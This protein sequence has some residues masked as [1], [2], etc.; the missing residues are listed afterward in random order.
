MHSCDDD[1]DDARVTICEP[2]NAE[3]KA[4]PVGANRQ[5]SKAASVVTTGVDRD[6]ISLERFSDAM[7]ECG[8]I[9]YE[10]KRNLYDTDGDYLRFF[11]CSVSHKRIWESDLVSSK[12]ERCNVLA[13]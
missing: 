4:K 9:D 12:L 1:D 8:R 13:A 5:K 11:T 10:S 7:V 2:W 6:T 3:R